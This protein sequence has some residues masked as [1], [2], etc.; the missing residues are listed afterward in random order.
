MQ[1][2]LQ[3]SAYTQRSLERELDDLKLDREAL[4]RDMKQRNRLSLRRIAI[5]N[6]SQS[7]R[8]SRDDNSDNDSLDDDC[9]FSMLAAIQTDE[10]K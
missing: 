3:T 7:S 2:Q 8:S 9:F 10:G 6:S 1:T 5:A 4:L